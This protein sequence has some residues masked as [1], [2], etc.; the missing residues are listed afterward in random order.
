[1]FT[2]PFRGH[3]RTTSVTAPEPQLMTAGPHRDAGTVVLLLH[4]G[5]DRSLVRA[6]RG[7][8]YLRMVPF[9]RAIVRSTRDEQ[10]AVWLLRN[11]YR[12]WN[13][14]ELHPVADAR[15]ALDRARERH[16]GAPVVLVGHSMG[17]RVALRVADHPSVAGVCALAPWVEASEPTGPVAGKT[18]LIAHGEKDRVTDPRLSAA[19][20]E[21]VGAT[22]VPVRGGDHSMLRRFR[23]WNDIVTG[24][25]RRF[26]TGAA[27]P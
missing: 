1:M 27:E 10:V 8:A 15:W 13:D 24:F 22:Y 9:A 11:R 14:P 26:V 7:V 12:G 25:V 19:Y 3:R 17:G 21:A 16:P 23:V 20:A 6:P 18:V 4:G 2:H 5:Q